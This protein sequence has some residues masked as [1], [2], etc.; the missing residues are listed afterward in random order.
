MVLGAFIADSLALGAHW[1]YDTK[2]IDKEAGRITDYRDPLAKNYHPNR[3][4]GGQTHY[5]DQMLL[6]FEYLQKAEIFNSEDYIKLWAEFYDSYDGYKDHAMKETRKNLENSK[7]PYGS[8]STDLSGVFY[9][10]VLTAFKNRSANLQADI[11][12][13]VRMTHDSDSVA[14]AGLF[15]GLVLNNVLEGISPVESINKILES[16]KVS[17]VISG[18]VRKGLESVGENTRKAIALFGQSCPADYGLP[19]VVHLI[20]RY[21]NDFKAGMVENVMAGG[22]SAARGIFAGAVL[23]AHNGLEKIDKS[24]I[25]GLKA[26]EIIAEGL[27]SI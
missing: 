18:L 22:D 4:A 2:R 6:F 9:V 7:A 14:E 20:A 25:S 10:P 21:E 1:I 5:G 26:G 12:R 17:S 8:G 3:A 19:G 15:L 23:G 24:W 16:G 27:K 11:D 13:A